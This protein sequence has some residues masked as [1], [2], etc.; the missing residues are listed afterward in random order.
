MGLTSDFGLQLDSLTDTISFVVVPATIIYFIF[1]NSTVGAVI[2][3]VAILCGIFRLAKFNLQESTKHYIGISTPLF[4]AMVLTLALAKSLSP[5]SAWATLPEPAYAAIFLLLAL[6]MI[7]PLKFPG[8][9]GAN[10]SKYKIRAEYH[11]IVANPFETD[12]NRIETLRFAATHH[13]GPAILRIFPLQF[14]PGTP[15]YDR[16]REAG[17]IGRRHESAYQYTYTGKTHVLGSGYLDVWLRVVLNLRNHRLP[18][19]VAHRLIDFAIHPLVRRAIDRRWFVPAAYRTYRVGRFVWRKL[20]FQPFIRPF[21]YLKRKP[22][23]EERH[24]EDE[25]T[26]PRSLAAREAVDEGAVPVASNRSHKSRHA[27]HA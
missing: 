20:I 12:V 23:Y 15:L 3:A 6:T 2:G 8:F 25:V 9:K 14:Y 11:Y 1:F 16:A 26:L 18:A 24:P 17:M 10:F 5:E 22:R 27:A 4:S 13:R 21:K 7:S 19:A